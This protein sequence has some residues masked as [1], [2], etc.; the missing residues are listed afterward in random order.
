MLIKIV[1][2]LAFLAFISAKKDCSSS[3]GNCLSVGKNY[4]IP[5]VRIS[6]DDPHCSC[7]PDTTTKIVIND[8][9]YD[10]MCIPALNGKS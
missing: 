7:N 6:G 4:C 5:F 8:L 1:F 10:Y 9:R 3:D 2:I